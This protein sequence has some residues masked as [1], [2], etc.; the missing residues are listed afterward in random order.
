MD[1]HTVIESDD[2]TGFVS[3]FFRKQHEYVLQYFLLLYLSTPGNSN[4]KVLLWY[5][6]AF[7]GRQDSHM[8][9]DALQAPLK[10]KRDIFPVHDPFFDRFGDF[11]L[12]LLGFLFFPFGLIRLFTVVGRGEQFVPGI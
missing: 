11:G 4:G 2:T 10:V 5:E 7:H 6:A 12:C 1:D 3:I 8:I 9:E